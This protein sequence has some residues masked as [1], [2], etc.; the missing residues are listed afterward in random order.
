MSVFHFPLHYYCTFSDSSCNYCFFCVSTDDPILLLKMYGY[1]MGISEVI[2][3]LEAP[4]CHTSSFCL[5]VLFCLFVCLFFCKQNRLGR[6]ELFQVQNY[7]HMLWGKS[8]WHPV[9][10]KSNRFNKSALV[11]VTLA[12]GL[13]VQL[14]LYMLV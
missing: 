11:S 1:E 8:G 10:E 4:T 3:T 9:R 5:F 2:R 7:T 13:S 6:I 14:N 12:S